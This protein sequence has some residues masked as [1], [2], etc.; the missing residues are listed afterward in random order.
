MLNLGLG[1]ARGCSES[2]HCGRFCRELG[3]V[4]RNS[5]RRFEIGAEEV[6]GRMKEESVQVIRI[7]LSE[8]STR[9]GF[10]IISHTQDLKLLFTMGM[11]YVAKILLLL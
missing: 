2:A 9:G 4:G 3:L 5:E 8:D 10:Q 1:C 11:L 7:R 6:G